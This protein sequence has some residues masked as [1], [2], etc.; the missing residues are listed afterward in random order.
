MGRVLRRAFLKGAAAVAVVGFDPIKKSWAC[1]Q[2]PGVLAI[3]G[4]DGQLL[5]DAATLQAAADDF[6]HAVHRIPTAVLVPGSIDDVRRLVQF[7]RACGVKVAAARGVG[8]SHGTQGQAQVEAGV[9]IDMSA[10][11]EIH[12]I[13]ADSALVDAG[14]R[15]I[16]LLA[17]TV[18]LGASPPTLTDFI[19]LSVGGTLSVGGI[20]GQAFRSGLQVDNVL[21]L[22]VVTG[23]GD[24]VTCSPLHHPLLFNAV[25]AGLGQFGI[26]VRARVRLVPVPP[27]VR[28]Y[29][30][31]YTSAATFMADQEMLIED[32]RFDYVE[33]SV[34]PSGDGGWL[35]ALEAARYFTPGAEPDDAALLAGLSFVPG[36]SSHA[37][38][39]YFDFAN[40]L[41]PVIDFLSQIG[42]WFFPHPWLNLFL[43]A[44]AAAAFVEGVLAGT[45]LDDTGQGPILLYPFKR[46]KITAPFAILPDAPRVFLFSLLRTAVPPTP[47]RVAA[48]V[49]ANRAIYE[50]A[51][52]IGGER[53]TIDSVP[54]TQA[55]WQQHF[56]PKWL[57]FV[58]AKILYDP[59]GVLTP[60]QGIFP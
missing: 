28:V 37:D 48:L 7:A 36:T 19:G 50:A 57:P 32:G 40:R 15:W 26:V 56:G 21:E 24:L 42:V 30:A 55:D 16:D 23:R 27:R 20:G 13:T 39:D 34:Q 45:T 44:P 60:G 25:R 52:D 31:I 18:P 2:G 22:Q 9:V 33:G 8:E 35:F 11:N 59:D 51:R 1:A 6:G 14:V 4:L 38:S 46:S 10:L 54:M 5:T 58:L 43:P 17:E 49:D 3:P 53:Y 29:S 41:A 12:E 47:E